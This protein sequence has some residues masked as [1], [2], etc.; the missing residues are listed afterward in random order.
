MVTAGRGRTARAVVT[1]GTEE[2]ATSAGLRIPMN[3]IDTRHVW[4]CVEVW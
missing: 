3:L 2:S 1:A 4:H